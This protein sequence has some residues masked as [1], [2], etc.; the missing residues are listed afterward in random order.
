MGG[1]FKMQSNKFSTLKSVVELH[2]L[3]LLGMLCGLL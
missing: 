2:S 1:H 3:D